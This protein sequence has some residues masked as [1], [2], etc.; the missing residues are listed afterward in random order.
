MQLFA[1]CAFVAAA[2]ANPAPLLAARDD[3]AVQGIA[4][5][6]AA[7]A[8]LFTQHPQLKLDFEEAKANAIANHAAVML[9]ANGEAAEADDCDG[10]D[11]PI[12]GCVTADQIKNL[13][14]AASDSSSSDDSED[15]SSTKVQG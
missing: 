9:A 12:L 4:A 15:D 13:T 10:L 5:A 1:I 14:D 7:N 11:L 3:Q 2:T 6:N 8:N